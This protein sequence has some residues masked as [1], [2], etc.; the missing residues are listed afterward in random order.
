[1]DDKIID[2]FMRRVCP[3]AISAP[4]LKRF[5]VTHARFCRS[6]RAV[7]PA[8][9][10]EE[11]SDWQNRALELVYP[12]VFPE[13]NLRVKIRDA[14]SRQ[15]KNKAVYVALDVTPEGERAG[16]GALDCR[17]EGAKFWLSMHE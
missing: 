4:I 15:V 1:M 7:S 14:E 16:S 11:V 12:I 13:L 9:V 5:N 6:D 3:P 10:L 8:A 17:N 2:C